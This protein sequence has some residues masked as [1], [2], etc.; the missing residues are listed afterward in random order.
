MRLEKDLLPAT[1][2]KGALCI[3]AFLA[4]CSLLAPMQLLAIDVSVTA[5]VPEP[6]NPVTTG[7]VVFTGY[8]YPNAVMT[9]TRDGVP[10]AT[11]TAN[12]SGA[13]TLTNTTEQGVY[14]F[15]IVGADSQNRDN[16]PLVFTI[17]VVADTITSFSNVFLGPTIEADQTTIQEDGSLTVRGTTIPDAQVSIF[18][19]STPFT[20][21][22]TSGA[23]GSWSA[24]IAGADAE[25]GAHTAQAQAESTTSLE[26][27]LSDI[28]NFVVTEVTP[29]DVC[30]TMNDADIN[31]DAK[32]DLVDF[33]IMLYFWNAVNPANA[34][35]DI[36]A[37]TVVNETDFSILL[38]N[39]TG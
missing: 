13:Y 34:R 26:S 11:A 14:T 32:V 31:C 21:T 35:A 17:T 16:A 33:S 39:W 30:D 3:G 37:D 4:I 8:A 27:E 12:A 20:L 10:V 19:N 18:V 38:F 29:V 5:V 6:P 28:I 25:A 1:K 36:N 9:L 24:V 2:N 7:T 23:D 22:T 15:G